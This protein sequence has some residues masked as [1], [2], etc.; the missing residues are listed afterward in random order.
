MAEHRPFDARVRRPGGSVGTY[1]ADVYPS[2]YVQTRGGDSRFYWLCPHQIVPKDGLERA[3][4]SASG[5]PIVGFRSECARP[6]DRLEVFYGGCWHYAGT[7]IEVLK[8]LSAPELG[9][10]S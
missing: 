8:P 6:G 9:D 5:V 7:V 3:R 10:P 4:L 1:C 2:G